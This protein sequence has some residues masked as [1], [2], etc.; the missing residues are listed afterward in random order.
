M[1]AAAGEVEMA[2]GDVALSTPCRATLTAEVLRV[3]PMLANVLKEA[4]QWIS[5]SQR[6]R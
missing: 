5:T 6:E 1:G 2:A 4:M 3:P